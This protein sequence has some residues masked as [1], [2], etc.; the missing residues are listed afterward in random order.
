MIRSPSRKKNPRSTGARQRWVERLWLVTMAVDEAAQGQL[1]PTLAEIETEPGGEQRVQSGFRPPNVPCIESVQP[2]AEPGQKVG[3]ALVID[4]VVAVAHLREPCAELRQ[5][6]R[7]EAFPHRRAIVGKDRIEP[8]YDLVGEVLL[9]AVVNAD[10][11]ERVG[12]VLEKREQPGFFPRQRI[13]LSLPERDEHAR[14]YGEA[15]PIGHRRE[16]SS[17]GRVPVHERLPVERL[18]GELGGFVMFLEAQEGRGEQ[19]LGRERY[20]MDR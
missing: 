2:D 16:R 10:H 11:V 6:E 7:R 20:L 9:A 18:A 15:G 14:R 8:V 5:R 17:A 12:D 19:V 4:D 13:E 1:V 3:V